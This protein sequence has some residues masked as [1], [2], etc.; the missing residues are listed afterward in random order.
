MMARSNESQSVMPWRKPDPPRRVLAIRMHAIGD[1]ALTFPALTSFQR[2]HPSTTV[3]ILTTSPC[4]SLVKVLSFP[5]DVYSFPVCRTRRER[6]KVALEFAAQMRRNKYDVVLDLQRNWVSRFIRRM[7]AASAWSEFERYTRKHACDRTL[8][9]F[10]SAGFA[11]TGNDFRLPLRES[12]LSK[13]RDQLLQAGWDGTSIPIIINPAGLWPSRQWPIE[14]YLNLC[15]CILDTS[16]NQILLLGT[17]RIVEKTRRIKEVFR[18]H[19]IDLTQRTTLGEALGILQFCGGMVT[20][21]SG[22]MHMAWATGIPLVALFGSTNHV[23]SAPAGEHVRLFDSGD[24]PCGAC[25]SEQCRFND[26][27]CLTRVSPEM[28]HAALVDARKHGRSLR[29]T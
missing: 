22:L 10:D 28:V 6:V 12:V 2:H 24:L 9:T 17:D 5:G 8:E 1:V 27:H 20:E 13:A 15:R 7:S 14:N 11:G 18:D 16:G 21:D 4:F 25:M 23:M 3:D 19:T 29:L 26:V